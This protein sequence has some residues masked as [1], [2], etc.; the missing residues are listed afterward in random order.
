MDDFGIKTY[1]ER[2]SALRNSKMAQHPRPDV[3]NFHKTCARLRLGPIIPSKGF[4]VLF[5]NVS[6]ELV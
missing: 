2:I 6:V 5:L 4:L 1:D 3:R